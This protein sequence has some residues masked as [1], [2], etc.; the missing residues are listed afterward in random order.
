MLY[1]TASILI[2]LLNSLP[3]VL[4][5]L[6]SCRNLIV[7][8]ASAFTNASVVLVQKHRLLRCQQSRYAFINMFAELLAITEISSSLIRLLLFV[9][10]VLDISDEFCRLLNTAYRILNMAVQDFVVTDDL[11][12]ISGVSSMSHIMRLCQIAP[13]PF[14]LVVMQCVLAHPR[15][16]VP[17][18]I[19]VDL[20]CQICRRF[21][22]R[23]CPDAESFVCNISSS[24][25]KNLNGSDFS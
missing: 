13:I 21:C 16:V 10:F 6:L 1:S 7:L 2:W 4:N 9:A 24:L 18:S 22:P 25:S 3:L 12:K 15:A 8:L 17:Y 19:L 23:E 14:P 11:E 20:S 5:A